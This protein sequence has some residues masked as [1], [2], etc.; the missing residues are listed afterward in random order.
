[1]IRNL[2]LQISQL[3]NQNYSILEQEDQQTQV[4]HTEKPTQNP[5]PKPKLKKNNMCDHT[6]PTPCP[7]CFEDLCDKNIA[8]M[9]CGHKFHFKCMVKWNSTDNGD[10]CPLC[11][12]DLGLPDMVDSSDEEEE[13]VLMISDFENDLE[14]DDFN[15]NP[16]PN[17]N[18][19]SN[20][21]ELVQGDEDEENGDDSGSDS[22]S[23]DNDDENTDMDLRE[24]RYEIGQL[25]DTL[26][27]NFGIKMSCQC[28]D[29]A[30]LQ[31]NFCSEPFCACKNTADKPQFKANPFNKLYNSHF[32]A[33]RRDDDMIQALG[34]E[35][36][37][38]EDLRAPSV[39]SRC[40]ANRDTIIKA[41]LDE[42]ISE[43]GGEHY[44]ALLE[45][46]EVKA[47]FFNLYHDTSG[48][49]NSGLYRKY[50]TYPTLDE[51][52]RYISEKFNIEITGNT[53]QPEAAA[54]PDH[55]QGPIEASTPEPYSQP[56][57]HPSLPSRRA[58]FL[59]RVPLRNIIVDER[60]DTFANVTQ[61]HTLNT[62]FTQYDND[63]IFVNVSSI[64]SMQ[65]RYRAAIEED[66]DTQPEPMS[67]TPIL[68]R[69]SLAS[70]IF[71]PPTPP[72]PSTQNF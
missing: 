58:R 37:V 36:P 27:G 22:D 2:T 44:E 42:Y 1:M 66:A 67:P 47:I 61:R 45:S 12:T 25:L 56:T 10:T 46:T 19:N 64:L 60:R 62:S 9:D 52:R 41:T 69:P 40:F 26:G 4:T 30:L 13:G 15:P 57:S 34:I 35:N 63:D 43:N 14:E 50:P 17:P 71:R 70:V 28:C 33:S 59:S 68:T 48:Q 20:L 72:R 5:K 32:D 7:I 21:D 65:N 39:C 38:D 24:T 31:C 18:P 51:F 54:D 29:Q 53:S 11:R 8:V 23:D 55:E 49:D 16:I 3:I 6:E